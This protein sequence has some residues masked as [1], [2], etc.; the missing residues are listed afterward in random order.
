MLR[1]NSTEFGR[2]SE[3]PSKVTNDAFSHVKVRDTI[4]WDI[5]T[6]DF[7]ASYTNGRKTG[8]NA[9]DYDAAGNIVYTETGH[10]GK[11]WTTVDAAG[12]VTAV[13]AGT[14]TITATS[15]G[16]SGTASVTVS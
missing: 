9:P 14:A 10:T 6:N 4:Y 15:E 11:Q 1:F 12:L 13:S 3:C 8:V 7:S 5:D 16:R 2:V